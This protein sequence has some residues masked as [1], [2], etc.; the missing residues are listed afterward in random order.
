MLLELFF[1]AAVSQAPIVVPADETA[2]FKWDGGALK[3][4]PACR[5]YTLDTVQTD[6]NCAARVAKGEAGPALAIAARTLG[7]VPARAA[8]AVKLLEHAVAVTDSPAVHYL[9]GNVLSSGQQAQPDY[10]RAVHH[11]TIAADRGNPAAAD[12]LAGLLILG[13]GAPR[14]VPRGLRYYE[15]AAANGFPQA[16]I[17]LGILYLSGKQLPKD[18]A[19]GQAWLDAA[20]AA[21]VPGAAQYAALAKAQDKIRNFQLIPAPN[22]ADVKAVRYGTFDNPDIPP[23][24]GFDLAFQAVH[25]APIDD[26]ATLA[27]LEAGK[28]TL[29][30]PY[31]YELARRLG[32][33]DAARS[34]ITYLVARMRMAYDSS[35]CSDPAATE[36]LGAWDKLFISEMA[37]LFANGLP[38]APLMAAALAQE[39]T[40]PA[41]T[42]PWWVCR[43]GMAAMTA[44]MEGKPGPLQ[45]NP[46]SDWPA[47][48]A[49]ARAP[50]ERRAAAG[51]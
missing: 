15:S 26:P 3:F 44:A 48:R 47:L 41:D 8:D 11:L 4:D 7:T 28:S 17:R 14:D 12:L 29:P 36:S 43:S 5:D 34:A 33:K 20:A 21:N 31:L 23:G 49:Q 32:P 16:A 38:G 51:K 40:L 27:R 46:E 1:A 25:D 2:Q 9:L 37:F 13:K 35:R 50:Y 39:A 42:Q 22:P 30:T 10:R 19:K 18:P 6:T 45:L 24:F